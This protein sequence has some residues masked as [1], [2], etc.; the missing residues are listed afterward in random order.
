MIYCASTPTPLGDMLLVSDESHLC[1]AYFMDQKYIPRVA[2]HW[3]TDAD[4]PVMRQAREE[5]DEFFRGQRRRFTV[6]VNPRGTAFQRRVWQ[7]LAAIPYGVT[8]SYGDLARQL[9]SAR[10]ARAVGSATGRNPLSVIVP[11]HRVLGAGGSLT[12]YAGGLQRKRAL[13][14]LEG[15]HQA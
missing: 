10:H 6:P 5:L 9:G 14:C 11:C 13:L 12:G 3:R 1:G 4:L 8:V 7:L 2:P 15:I